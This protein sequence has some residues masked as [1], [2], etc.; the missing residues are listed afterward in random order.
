[1]AITLIEGFDFLTAGDVLTLYPLSD[2][3]SPSIITGRFGGQAWRADAGNQ[4][5]FL[6]LP[7]SGGTTVTIGAAIYIP[8][9]LLNGAGASPG[10]GLIRF[11]DS[12]NAIQGGVQ[13]GSNGT[14]YVTRSTNV[15]LATGNPGDVVGDAWNY[16]EVEWTL[17]DTVGVVNV[18]V[19]GALKVSVSGVDNKNS[20]SATIGSVRLTPSGT[21]TNGLAFDDIYITDTAARLG[22]SRVETLRPT[23]DD[24]TQQWGRSTGANNWALVDETPQNGDTDYVLAASAGLVDKYTMGDLSSVPSTIHAV[25]AVMVARKDDAAARSLRSKLTSGSTL[26]NGATRALGSNYQVFSDVWALDPNTSGAWSASAVNALT[27]GLES[28]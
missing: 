26:A 15:L 14:L 27:L 28:I 21:G 9:T 5:R 22:E 10:T 25:Q 2:A 7:A 13:M 18:Y 17:S 23:A 20:G 3:L 24:G 4:N 16:I 12:A 19:N 6:G 1:M 11:Y 8:Q